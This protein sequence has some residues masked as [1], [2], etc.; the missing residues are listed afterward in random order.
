[1]KIIKNIYI[2]ESVS[3]TTVSTMNILAINELITKIRKYLYNRNVNIY[4]VY[5]ATV[6]FGGSNIT[7]KHY[8]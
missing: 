1:M 5:P 6:K 3:G 8:P 2:T 4:S 7:H